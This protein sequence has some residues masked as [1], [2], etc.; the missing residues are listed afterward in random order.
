MAKTK[1]QLYTQ[2]ATL[3]PDNV[4]QE[5]SAADVRTN[6]NDI[7]EAS[8]NLVDNSD[9]MGLSTWS[10]GYSY[11]V[12]EGVIYNNLIYKANTTPTLGVWNQAQWTQVGT[13]LGET[14]T[15]AYAGDKGKTAYDHS[16]VLTGNPHNTSKSDIGLGNVDNTSDLNKPI[17][18]ATQAELDLKQTGFPGICATCPVYWSDL[19]FNLTTGV[20]V[21]NSTNNGTSISALNPLHFFV[22]GS[23]V[24]HK[25]SKTSAVTFTPYAAMSEGIWYYYFDHS[26]N[27]IASK[28]PFPTFDSCSPVLRAYF[29]TTNVTMNTVVMETHPN[30]ISAADHEHKHAQGAIWV[31][32]FDLI[33]NSL[34][35]GSPAST[36]LNT[37]ISLTTGKCLDDNLPHTTTNATSGLAYTQDLGNITA[38]NITTSNAALMRT[39]YNNAIGLRMSDA[40]RFPFTSSVGNNPYYYDASGVQQEIT[41]NCFFRSFIYELQDAR[42][43]EAIRTRTA[44]QTFTSLTNAQTYTWETLKGLSPTLNDREIKVLYILDYEYRTNYD[45]GCKKSVLRAVTNLRTQPYTDIS[46]GSTAIVDSNVSLSSPPSGST[47]LTQAQLNS[48][49]ADLKFGSGVAAETLAAGDFAMVNSAGTI[50]K[51]LATADY[52]ANRIVGRI[53]TGGNAASTV[54]FL[55]KGNYTYTSHGFTIGAPLYLTTLGA[56]STSQPA[57]GN[58]VIM[59]GYSTSINNIY[60]EISPNSIKLL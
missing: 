7:V 52:T 6:L 56:L 48:E 12:D 28:T 43:G 47:S 15:T 1:S 41:S 8:L 9:Y 16:Q 22:D 25:F 37:C 11:V 3:I 14:S 35:S 36:G 32:G 57:A 49:S 10:S 46:A 33:H 53:I 13:V 39:T 26:G 18:T 31:S 29:D 59:M 2:I 51:A 30:D 34:S 5:I 45:V 20:L 17:A 40:V 21:I 42:A 27:P 23:G 38:A 54:T 4:T 60:L 55:R 58:T 24:I 50:A 19:S 44:T